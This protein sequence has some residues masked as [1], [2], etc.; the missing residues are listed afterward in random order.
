HRP[1]DALV[2]L[3]APSAQPL[4]PRGLALRAEALAANGQAAEAWGLLGALRQQHAWPQALL[5]ERELRWAEASLHE[6]ADANALAER[7]DALP[8][9]LKTEPAVVD[10]YATR[11]AAFGWEDAAT[12]SIEHALDNRWDEGLATRYGLLPVGRL[13]H[14]RSQVERWLK[15]HPGS[16]ALLV[17][18]AR[19]AQA[20]GD[21]PQGEAALHRALA[22]GGGSE[23][24]EALGDG[25]ARSGDE[26]RARQCYANALA[27]GRGQAVVP[28]PPRE[29]EQRI[30]DEALVEDRDRYGVPRLRE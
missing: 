27:A 24:W 28:L 6:A 5:D 14:R 22:Q 17:T 25:Y 19:L 2:A 15:A 21:W 30:A 4:P 9:T 1:T 16:P 13:E 29:L 3:D 18:L 8:K 26:Y 11:A 10:A 23:A 7:W 12:R 20:A